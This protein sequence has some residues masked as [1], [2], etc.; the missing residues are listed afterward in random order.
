MRFGIKTTGFR[1]L[2]RMNTVTAQ[3]PYWNMH[4]QV[5]KRIFGNLLFDK[6]YKRPQASYKLYW[7]QH[8]HEVQKIDRLYREIEAKIRQ[9]KYNELHK[10][11]RIERELQQWEASIY[12]NE[13]YDLLD[14]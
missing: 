11:S 13:Y 7:K 10:N 9:Q 14:N 4:K 3:T 1:F 8:K 12:K 2:L 5:Q 6:W